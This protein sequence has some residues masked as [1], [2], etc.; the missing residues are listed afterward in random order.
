MTDR[1]EKL[2]YLLCRCYDIDFYSN[3]AVFQTEFD[4]TKHTEKVENLQDFQ[5]RYLSMIQSCIEQIQE[6]IEDEFDKEFEKETDN[7]N[8]NNSSI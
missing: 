5:K 4:G 6:F 8:D 3:E 1:K 7:D 2:N